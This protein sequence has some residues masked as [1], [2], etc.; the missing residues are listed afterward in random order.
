MQM[1]RDFSFMKQSAVLYFVLIVGASSVFFRRAFPTAPARRVS[2]R[3]NIASFGAE[4]KFSRLILS[5]SL[6]GSA[7]SFLVYRCDLQT[8]HRAQFLCGRLA[9]QLPQVIGTQF[10]ADNLR[11]RSR[12][13]PIPPEPLRIAYCFTR[14][15]YVCFQALLSECSTS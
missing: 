10:C 11:R 7:Y 9:S 4:A 15:G 6:L 13:L 2:M 12:C 1:L 3:K 8:S 5:S 14:T